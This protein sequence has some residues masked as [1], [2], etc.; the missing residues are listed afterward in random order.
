MK[1]V[2]SLPLLIFFVFLGSISCGPMNSSGGES[3]VQ[4]SP[5]DGGTGFTL[6]GWLY[7]PESGAAAT[8]ADASQDMGRIFI[9][10][11][12]N[13]YSPDEDLTMLRR[14]VES[15]DAGSLHA[16]F[17]KTARATVEYP[18]GG[19]LRERFAFA[20]KM[21]EE[22]KRRILLFSEGS[23][24]ATHK[25]WAGKI[26][27]ITTN[28]NG[29]GQGLSYGG[30]LYFTAEGGLDIDRPSQSYT[31]SRIADVRLLKDAPSP[32]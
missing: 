3:A 18:R 24:D 9:K 16:T 10:I 23:V 11:I 13:S 5:R 7:L 31:P 14:F 22:G 17:G 8:A 28:A 19:G 29:E 26:I 1:R 4:L 12:V 25:C 27:D 30:R 2:G 21:L 15:G 20:A 32:R 6:Q